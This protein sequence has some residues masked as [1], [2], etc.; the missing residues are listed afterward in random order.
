LEPADFVFPAIS[1]NGIVNRGKHISH[2]AVQA[3]I[4]EATTGAG[5]PR[6][7]G[8]GFTTHTY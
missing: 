7:A 8:D 1:S 3:W 5:I 2:N 6:G 4:N